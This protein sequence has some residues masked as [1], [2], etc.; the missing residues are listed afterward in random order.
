MEAEETPSEREHRERIPRESVPKDQ[1]WLPIMSRHF[2]TLSGSFLVGLNQSRDYSGGEENTGI[3][4]NW[5][6]NEL[7]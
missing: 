2:E 6:L 3:V 4:F 7:P 5:Y 1:I